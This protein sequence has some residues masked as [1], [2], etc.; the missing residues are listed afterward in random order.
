MQRNAYVLHANR[1]DRAIEHDLVLGYLV[2]L[3]F[4][5]LGKVARGNR[6]IELAGIG[7]LPNQLDRDAVQRL[8]ILLRFGAALGVVGFDLGA[9]GLEHLAVRLVG[10]QRLATRQQEVAGVAVLDLHNVADVT[11]LLDSF[12][13]NDVHFAAPYFTT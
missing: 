12:E 2:T 13:Q 11:E 1:L 10:A 3:G 7:G 5:R 6:S 9:V 4:Q 8:G